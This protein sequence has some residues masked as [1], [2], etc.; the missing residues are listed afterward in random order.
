M[1]NKFAYLG[2]NKKILFTAIGI[3]VACFTLLK[4]AYPLPDMF[5]DSL[6]YILWAKM[7][8]VVQYR[9]VGYSRFLGYIHKYISEAPIAVSAVQ[10]LLFLLSGLFCLFSVD[11]LFKLPEK[12]KWVL[13]VLLVF[14]PILIFQTNLIASDSLFCSLTVMWAT[15]CFWIVK[16]EKWWALGMQI[17]LLYLAFQVR[18]TALF[19]PFIAV[20]ALLFF[21]RR[22]IYKAV[23]VLLTFGIIMAAKSKHEQAV[24]DVTGVK[25][26]SGF[27]GW[28]LANNVLYYYDKIKVDSS[29]FPTTEM[30]QLDMAVRYHYDSVDKG[31]GIGSAF[32]W[33][34]S[35]PLKRF[36]YYYMQ[37]YRSA[38]FPMWF[39]VSVLYQEYATTLIK[40]DPGAFLKYYMYPNAL[41]YFYPETEQLRKY[42]ADN[43]TL[44]TSAANW[45]NLESRRLYTNVPG[46]Q[47]KITAVYP[48]LSLLLN[49]LNIGAII[50]FAI[51]LVKNWRRVPVNVKGLFITWTMFF[52][53]YMLFSIFATVVTLRYM[54]PLYI[55][56]FVMPAILL[57]Y[58]PGRAEQAP[59]AQPVKAIPRRAR[60][61]KPSQKQKRK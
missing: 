12:A 43:L 28:Q 41:N 44:D 1:K 3:S 26:F 33:S 56:G 8:A 54:D 42:D 31:P 5:P 32:M 48:A 38:Y 59:A 57:L 7:N 14:N 15:C 11:F 22:I 19:Y 9:P 51:R 36:T 37:R 47:E 20:T 4:R 58:K 34:R 6:S 21:T 61:A 39:R 50:V 25:V 45:F 2:E 55:L 10:Y 13:M 49:L 35:S 46:L 16:Q 18:Y 27:S 40:Q 60:A 30:K 17:L 24:Y 53:G 29:K 23:G 52:F